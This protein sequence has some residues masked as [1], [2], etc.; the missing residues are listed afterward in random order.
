[1]MS[2]L[3]DNVLEL[4]NTKLMIGPSGERYPPEDKWI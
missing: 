1:M 2:V 4:I 3:P